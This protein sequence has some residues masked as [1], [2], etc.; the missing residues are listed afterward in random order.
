MT[1]YRKRVL[2]ERYE[3]DEQGT[4]RAGTPSTAVPTHAEEE[5]RATSPDPLALAA[6]ARLDGSMSPRARAAPECVAT[7]P[8]GPPQLIHGCGPAWRTC[9]VIFVDGGPFATVRETTA[10]HG[11]MMLSGWPSSWSA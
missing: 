1:A 5:E 7:A 11:V 10:L 3:S 6:V 8:P 4:E 2:V 9:V